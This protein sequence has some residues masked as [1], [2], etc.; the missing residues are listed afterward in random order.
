HNAVTGKLSDVAGLIVAPALFAALIGVRGRRGWWLAHAAVGTMFTALQ[1]SPAFAAQWGAAFGA[2]GLSWVTVCDPSD[3]LA[4]PVLLLSAVGFRTALVPRPSR[5]GPALVAGGVGLV[6]SVATS[7][8]GPPGDWSPVDAEVFLHNATSGDLELHLRQLRPGVDLDCDAV[9]ADPAQ[10]LPAA[11]FDAPVVWSMP[12]GA[13]VAASDLPRFDCT[14]V[15]VEGPTIAPAVIAWRAE[16][17]PS[18][19]V[20][21]WYSQEDRSLPLGGVRLEALEDGSIWV[22]DAEQ[23][24]AW[25]PEVADDTCDA[26]ADADRLEWDLARSGSATLLGR[27]DGLDGCVGLDLDDGGQVLRRYLCGLAPELLPFAPG[28]VLSWEEAVYD[29]GSDT[30]TILQEVDG[31]AVSELQLSRGRNL[32]GLRLRSVDEACAPAVDPACGTV[33]QT[34][35]TDAAWGPEPLQPVTVGEVMPLGDAL[36]Q[37]VHLERRFAVDTECAVGPARAGTDLDLA[38]LLSL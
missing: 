15:W 35:A 11:L 24:L 13:V 29:D 26:A 32:P 3:L 25:T 31:S 12:S 30:L 38:L 22:G 34:L 23:G 18:Q 8:G 37:L 16:D 10:R 5:V 17:Y 28:D 27:S 2:L 19:R 9:L 20:A 21:G 4:L 36:L 7:K 33:T 1:L 14:A 6:A